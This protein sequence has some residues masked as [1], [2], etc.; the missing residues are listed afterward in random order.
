MFQGFDSRDCRHT[1]TKWAP[2]RR[3]RRM[4][5]KAIVGSSKNITPELADPG[6]K[7]HA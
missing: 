6:V 4:F 2:G 5:V 3:C 1:N 7:R